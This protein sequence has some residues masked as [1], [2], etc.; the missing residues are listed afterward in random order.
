MLMI[1]DPDK[2]IYL[3]ESDYLDIVIERNEKYKNI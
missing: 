3:S 2:Y 1:I